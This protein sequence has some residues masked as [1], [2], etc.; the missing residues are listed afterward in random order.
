MLDSVLYGTEEDV[1]NIACSQNS[2]EMLQM[3]IEDKRWDPEMINRT[4]R[5]GHNDSA[6]STAAKE[7]F[8]NM[9]NGHFTPKYIRLYW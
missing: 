7:G 2:V 6:L 5:L 9:I 1:V 4:P 8:T 3:F